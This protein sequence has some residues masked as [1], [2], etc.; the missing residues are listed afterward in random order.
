[1]DEEP[2]K[3]GGITWKTEGNNVSITFPPGHDVF[4][5]G[6]T[7]VFSAL[8]PTDLIKDQGVISFPNND[9]ITA[10]T[11]NGLAQV[12]DAIK[13]MVEIFELAAHEINSSEKLRE[14]CLALVSSMAPKHPGG[15]SLSNIAL[16]MNIIQAPEPLPTKKIIRTKVFAFG[17]LEYVDTRSGQRESYTMAL[18]KQG[19][20]SY[21][22]QGILYKRV[23]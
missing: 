15:I 18:N 5:N 20:F 3:F 12:P 14:K 19:K 21:T 1:M 13:N 11:I 10:T 8:T 17:G 6:K 9:G 22:Q 2:N 16:G 7:V 23:G 4:P